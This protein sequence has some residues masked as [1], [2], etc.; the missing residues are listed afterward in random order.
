MEEKHIS[1]A[2]SLSLIQQM[3]NTAKQEQKDDGRGWIVWGWLLFFASTLSFFNAEFRWFNTFFFW[4]MFGIIT[5]LYFLYKLIRA[6]VIAKVHRV[7]TYTGDLL[8]K[9]NAGFF[10]S[11][12]LIIVA[13]NVGARVVSHKFNTFDPT[14]INIGF[15]LLMNLY[16][17]WILIYGTALNF[18]PSKVAAYIVWAI[19]LAAILLNDFRHVML[20]HS[21]AVLI[22]YI[23]PGHL[24]NSAFKRIHRNP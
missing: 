9:L 18:R 6:F 8:E 13:M 11:L 22:G 19:A 3:I 10:V 20:L 1:E 12:M 14:F 5:L 21:L 2:E 7:R 15:A 16:A 17:F 4:N 24:A 23:V